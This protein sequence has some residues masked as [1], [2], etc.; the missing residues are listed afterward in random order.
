MNFDIYNYFDTNQLFRNVYLSRDSSDDALL[1]LARNHQSKVA[2]SSSSSSS[3][4]TTPP[5]PPTPSPSLVSAVA[6][7]SPIVN[8]Q[9][10]RNNK[11]PLTQDQ[12]QLYNI[13]PSLVNLDKKDYCYGLGQRDAEVPYLFVKQSS[14]QT[15]EF[16]F[17][18]TYK[19]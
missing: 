17:P 3:P 19:Y 11:A 1:N 4:P 5:Q 18:A 14:L 9:Q 7:S 12:Q 8:S 16:S 6:P 10:Q 13:L 15:S 2:L